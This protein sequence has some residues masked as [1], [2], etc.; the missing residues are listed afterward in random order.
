MKRKIILALGV[1]LLI[2]SSVASGN[3]LGLPFDKIV[4]NDKQYYEYQAKSNLFLEA[5]VDRMRRM[6]E[7]LGESLNAR[8][9]FKDKEIRLIKPNV[10]IIT[11]NAVGIKEGKLVFDGVFGKSKK[12]TKLDNFKVYTEI[13]AIPEAKADFRLVI[14]IPNASSANTN[15]FAVTPEIVSVNRA[16]TFISFDVANAHFSEEGAYIVKLQMRQ[17]ATDEFFTIAEKKIDVTK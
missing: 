9:K 8:V 16:D 5:D 14:D 2:L 13:E 1:L 15:G 4:V 3:T 7:K 6:I 17:D 11:A 12:G 10:Q